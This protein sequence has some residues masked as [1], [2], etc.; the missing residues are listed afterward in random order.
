VNLS[1][2]PIAIAF[3]QK[4]TTDR[5]ATLQQLGLS[6]YDFLV[7]L[8]ADPINLP[9]LDRF[10]HHP[11]QV[12]FPDL[13]GANLAD[14]DLTNVNWIRAQLQG[15]NL[16]GANLAHADLLFANLTAADLTGA[17]LTGATL[18]ETVWTRAI[19]TNCQ[20]CQ[21]SGLTLAQSR[22]L[23]AHGAIGLSI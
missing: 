18:A 1:V 15:A 3:L 9:C 20:F 21:T 16:R 8:P 10:L 14:L 5:R 6:R 23:K 13:R 22:I 2:S 7:R 19:V 17:N 12:K 11:Q 4:N